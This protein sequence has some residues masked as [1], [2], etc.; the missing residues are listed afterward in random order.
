VSALGAR[1]VALAAA[2]ALCGCSHLPRSPTPSTFEGDWATKRD[3][4]SRRAYLY[5]GL[6]HRATATATHLSLA[7]REARARRLAEWLGWTPAELDARLAKERAEAAASE[8]FVV[9]IFTADPR[10]NDL[11]APR[12]DWR[13]ALKVEG[14]DLLPRRV[15]SI[16]RTSEV[17]GLYPYVGPFDIVYRVIVPMPQGGPIAGLPFTLEIS[18]ALGKLTMDFGRKDGARL[19]PQQPAPPP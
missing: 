14:A 11:D 18:S 9:A 3:A 6:D 10:R 5:D 1:A 12:S 17:L 7:V 8:E 15:T 16:D 19:F 2:V 13:V 4:E